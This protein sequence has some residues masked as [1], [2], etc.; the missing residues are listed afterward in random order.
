MWP[1]ATAVGKLALRYSA[2]PGRGDIVVT[3]LSPLP[4]LKRSVCWIV[5]TAG[6]AV[7]HN[8]S[9][10]A[11]LI[12]VNDSHSGKNKT[13]RKL[14]SRPIRIKRWLVSYEGPATVLS[15]MARTP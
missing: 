4:W 2:S 10:L 6:L 14:A 13:T 9:L 15:R 5:P 7:G 3:G 11:G 1:T 8:L 12:E